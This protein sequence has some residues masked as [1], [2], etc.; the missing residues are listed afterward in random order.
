[1]IPNNNTKPI[2]SLEKS[3]H[4]FTLRI[5]ESSG[6]NNQSEAKIEVANNRG[7]EFS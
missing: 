7:V 4:L 3:I 5:L 6:L 1:M 2:L